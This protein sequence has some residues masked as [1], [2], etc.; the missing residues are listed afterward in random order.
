MVDLS[1]R[2]YLALLRNDLGTFVARSFAELNAATPYHAN[3]HIEVVASKLDAV[4]RGETKRLV[5]MVPPRHLK[6]ICASVA[7]PA[8]LLGHDPS[9]QVICASYAQDLSEKL[10]RDTRQ[11]M[12]SVWYRRLFPAAELAG[13]KQSVG[14]FTTARN[15]YR[16]ATSVGGVLTGRGADIIV[17]DDPLKPD[18]ALSDTRRKSV[19]DW[20]DHTLLSRLNDKQNGAIVIIMQRLHQDDLVGHVLEQGGWEVVRL[21]AIAD[22]PAVFEID[23]P[24]GRRQFIRRPGDLLHPAREPQAVLDEIRR[25]TGEYNFAGQYQQSPA[26][27]GGGLVK[28][29]WFKIFDPA[30]PPRFERVVQ[31]WDTAIKVTELA[32]YSVCTT[33]GLAGKSAYLIDVFRQKLEYPDLKRAII[34]QMQRHCAKVVLIEDKASGQQLLQELKWSGV[35]QAK[36][37]TPEGDKIMRLHAQTGMIEN[38]FVHIPTSAPWLDAYLLELTTFPNAKHDDQADSTSQF[39]EWFKAASLRPTVRQVHI[40]YMG[41]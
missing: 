22:E 15:G 36:A 1:P 19:N 2:E 40:P 17:I 4:R 11:V 5:V 35:H 25:A 34:E 26:P 14:E 16:F 32:D 23:T 37:V 28:R 7:F 30:A 29:R 39:L 12:S 27:L 20:F 18:E 8:W 21:P 41:R 24:F 3:W 13:G 31:S 6:S 33:W 9:K 10:A 38:G